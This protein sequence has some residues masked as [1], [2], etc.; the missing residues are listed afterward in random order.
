MQY[1]ALDSF[2]SSIV[3]IWNLLPPSHRH[4]NMRSFSQHH[5]GTCCFLTMLAFIVCYST[6]A[7]A[8]PIG[9]APWV[10]N[11][12]KGIPCRGGAE[13]FGPFDY[14]QRHTLS[15]ELGIVEQYHF[16]PQ[17]EQLIA[18][19]Q[20]GLE[21]DVPDELNY[22]LRAWPNHHRALNSVIQYQVL[23]GRNKRGTRYPPAEC[24]LERAI[25]FSPKDGITRML[26]ANLLQRTGHK[27]RAFDQYEQALALKPKNIQI[28]YNF[29]LLLV[30]L[31]K[32][33]Q[34]HEYAFELYSKGFPLPG[35]KN[36]LKKTG[37]WNK[38]DEQQIKPVSGGVSKIQ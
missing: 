18:G 20:T 33:E 19:M 22:T 1:F 36:K 24:Y 34:A 3:I 15:A 30:D 37:H 32:Y 23:K 31:K 28:K 8:K 38:D 17:V 27:K 5:I 25:K 6:T 21:R 7:Y 12:L 2:C 14:L 4:Y 9:H 16:G 29:A 11:T 10:G 13:N 35:L 26:Y